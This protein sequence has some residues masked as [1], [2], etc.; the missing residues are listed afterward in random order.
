MCDESIQRSLRLLFDVLNTTIN[1]IVASKSKLNPLVNG[2]E[3]FDQFD[4][5]FHLL[6]KNMQQEV[7]KVI[8]PFL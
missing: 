5:E 7:V 1:L 8:K 2:G 3:A 6:R 4:V